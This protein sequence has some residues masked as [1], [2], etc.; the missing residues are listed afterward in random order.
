M[1]A[2][3]AAL[4]SRKSAQDTRD[5]TRE[6]AIGQLISVH[7][8]RVAALAKLHSKLSWVTEGGGPRSTLHWAE[9]VAL[10][11][12]QP[13]GT[14]TVQGVELRGMIEATGLDLPIT[15]R[16]AED[17]IAMKNKGVPIN[18]ADVEIRDAIKAEHATL[19]A[20]EAQL[21]NHPAEVSVQR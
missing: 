9:R 7:T 2:W 19:A 6:L 5:S 3:V 14:L 21:P 4:T 8:Q 1:A 10:M 15:R 20:L 16:V 11:S 17:M 13:L 12:G 18:E